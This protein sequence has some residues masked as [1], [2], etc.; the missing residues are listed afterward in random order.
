MLEYNPQNNTTS[1]LIKLYEP[2][3]TSI[4]S[5]TELSVVLKKAESVAYQLDF[6]QEEI[7]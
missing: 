2:L 5:K 1:L 7:L 6:T 4:G 3:P